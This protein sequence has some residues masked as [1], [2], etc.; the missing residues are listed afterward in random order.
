M[1]NLIL[2]FLSTLMILG[3]R[4]QYSKHIIQFSD[5]NGTPYSFDNPS[6]F[7]SGK[8]IE[9]RNRYNISLDSTD[10]PV[11]PR[12]IDSIRNA[13]AVTILNSSRWLN[14]VLIQSTDAA[15][16][17]KIQSFPFVKS[18]D[19]AA[20]RPVIIS[21]PK[22]KFDLEIVENRQQQ[23][24]TNKVAENYFDYGN[25]IGQVQIHEGEFL[26]N[27]GFRGEGMTIA[28]LDAGFRNYLTIPAFDSVRLNN[29]ILG[30]W[31]FV[32]NESSVNEDHPHGMWCFS[33][34]SANRP[35]NMV[36][37][38]PKAK[39]YLFRTE[40]AATEFPIEE[41]N[42]AAAAEMA[43][44]LGVDLITSSLGYFLFDDPSFN[45]SYA[46][47]NGQTTLITRA[48]DFAVKK[49]MI[50]TN[51]AG[52]EGSS[53]WKY[54]IAPADGDSVFTIG[55]INVNGQVAPFSSYGPSSDGRIKPNVT[56][57]GWSTFFINTNGS[58]A[59]GSGTSFSNPNLAGLITCLWQAFPEF[60]NMEILDAIQKSS[61]K[62][63]SPDD[64]VGY[65]IPNM[66]LAYEMLLKE[67]QIRNAARILGNDWLK[68][69]PVPFNNRIDI[70]LKSQKS[71]QAQLQLID[72]AGRNI[73]VQTVITQTNTYLYISFDKLELLPHGAYF[74]K[75]SDGSNK[76][77]LR[78]VK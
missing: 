3:T 63:A 27:Q 11:S 1:R 47:M 73:A 21:E 37:T 60:K 31:D 50:V 15:A 67:R 51:S 41:Q 38:A 32:L 71:G 16:L 74:I 48:A 40:D 4:A 17:S 75:Y 59:Q 55:A 34:I 2:S 7:L 24:R 42:W 56:S 61:D 70:L 64:R 44:S 20:T 36:G 14:Q 26:H 13:G 62:Y 33:I 23:M 10:F 28:V 35:G 12:Y 68:A 22:D 46:D 25:S 52:N 5:K 8:A 19:P 72:A 18:A 53:A 43:D 66:R 78:V 6:A 76:R 49:G 54:L 30:T 69:F 9:R 65:G 58:T 77:T 29:Q 57:V 39:F 45:H